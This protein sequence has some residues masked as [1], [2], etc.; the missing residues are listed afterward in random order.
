[1][2]DKGTSTAGL[3]SRFTVLTDETTK[4]EWKVGDKILSSFLNDSE[5]EKE[6][7]GY[8]KGWSIYAHR[9][10]MSDR[11]VEAIGEREGKIGAR[12]SGTWDIWITLESLEKHP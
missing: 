5:I 9:S 12:I 2:S 3:K 11:T 7:L 1:V 6:F 10:F 4:R 8:D